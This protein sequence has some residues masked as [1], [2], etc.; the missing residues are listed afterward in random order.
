MAAPTRG[1]RSAFYTGAQGAKKMEEE[2][3]KQ[4]A[5][6]E[7]MKNRT[8]MP[9]RFRV[10]A[11]ETKQVVILDDEPSFYQFE[12]NLKDPQTGFWSI[13]TGC[14]KEFES[15]PVCEST[16]KESYY[17][18]YLTVLDLTPFETKKNETVEFSRK[19]LVVKPAQHKK[20]N[21]FFAREGTLR[22]AIFDM[23]RDGEKDAS[24]G[25]DMEF[26]D[27]MPED[28][29]AGYVRTYKDQD[30]K[31]VTDDCSV[32]YDYLALFE[33]PD[34]DK[35]RAIVGGEPSPGSRA[36]D[37]D[38]VGSRAGR[39]ARKAAQEEKETDDWED[40]E[41]DDAPPFKADARPARRGK[42]AEE[43][44]P[45]RRG[46]TPTPVDESVD[47]DAEDDADTPPAR[48]SRPS[49]TRAAPTQAGRRARSTSAEEAEEEEKPA[50]GLPRRT[51]PRGR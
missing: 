28:E 20:I 35:L 40:A 9:F 11:G 18:M 45:A 1:K 44:E 19:L 42:V 50:R 4:K 5:R 26:V 29:L 31:K 13:F 49:D 47:D 36:H 15:C 24:I 12:H 41:G 51:A 22:G 27:W 38:A 32:P 21:R 34:A 30:G 7:A 37:R 46:R 8:H 39:P 14:V 25:N 3:E 33:E 48:R 43:A 2:Q 10:G 17:A 6:K 16:G 23:I